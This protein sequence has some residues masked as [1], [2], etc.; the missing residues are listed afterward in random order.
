MYTGCA[1]EC[2]GEY[3]VVLS[4]ML[5]RWRAEQMLSGRCEDVMPCVRSGQMRI[6]RR[7]V[8]DG[9]AVITGT[10]TSAFFI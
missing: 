1:A 9:Q 4:F 7:R 2:P 5:T 6:A 3:A 10:P 8:L